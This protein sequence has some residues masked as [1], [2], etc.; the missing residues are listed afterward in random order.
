MARI[1]LE[2]VK[3]S[4]GKVQA[5][6]GITID[7]KDK[8]FFV[9]FGPAGAGKTTILNCIAGINVP[10]EGIVKF[11]GEIVNLTDPA[12]RNVA[13]VFENYALY[14]Q[15][16]VYDN[17][18]AALRSNLYKTDEAEIKE[19]VYK[20]AKMM[21]MENLLER[22][23]SQLSNGQKQRVAMGR[24]LVR[25]PNVFLMDEPLAHLD[26]KLRNSMRTELKEM[27]ANLGSTCIYVTHD[28]MEAMALG[29]RIAI[30]KAGKIVQIGSG[31][32]IYYMPCN[33][34]VAQLMGDPEI[35]MIPAALLEE[36]GK[37]RISFQVNGERMETELPEDSNL[38]SNF[39]KDGLKEA[40]MGLRPQ[41][42]KYSFEQKEGY[43]KTTVYSYESIGNKSV[44]VAECGEYQLRMIAPNGLRVRIDQDIYVS[45]ELDHAMFFHR[46]TKEYICR[47]KEMQ[48]KAL[49]AEQEDK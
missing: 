25:T 19:R 26:A 13:M 36:N 7:V 9:L 49:A 30:I 2:N 48:F 34:F 33:E 41:N 23:P 4:F 46:E 3:K 11:N 14:P 21:K 44:I 1:Q 17:M 18:A 20:A 10:E 28:F 35:N 6:D 29:D 22:L 42:I 5:L 39:R 31:D 16:T 8:E 37:Y 45:L 27:Q 40:D 24:A 15:M 38:F 12:H 43:F 32:E 47:Y